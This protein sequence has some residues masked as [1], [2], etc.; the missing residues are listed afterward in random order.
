MKNNY[1]LMVNIKKITS[2]KGLWLL[3]FVSDYLKNALRNR[4]RRPQ[5]TVFTGWIGGSGRTLCFGEVDI[6]Q[7]LVQD[8]LFDRTAL[9][10]RDEKAY[11]K[12]EFFRAW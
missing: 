11:G 10:D 5:I 12:V 4:C 1:K 2:M 3:R 7:R 8:F 6:R 9:P